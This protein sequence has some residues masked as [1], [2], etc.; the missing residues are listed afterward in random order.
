MEFFL[1]YQTKPQSQHLF[2]SPAGFLN[3]HLHQWET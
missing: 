1:V 2:L 3:A